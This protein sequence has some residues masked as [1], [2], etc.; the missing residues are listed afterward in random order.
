[1]TDVTIELLQLPD[2]LDDGTEA[3]R[4]FLEYVEVGNA[5]SREQAGGSD[6]FDQTP[7]EALGRAKGRTSA[8]QH[9]HIALL[10]G[11]V[12]GVGYVDVSLH[13][14]AAPAHA[15]IDVHPDFRRRGIGTKL[16]SSVNATLQ[17]EGRRA[18]QNWILHPSAPGPVRTAAT[19]FGH[20]P[21]ESDAVRF[22]EKAGFVLE[23]VERM[24]TLD[25]ADVTPEVLIR[26]QEAAQQRAHGY[27]VRAWTG[28]SPPDQLDQL[29]DLHA[30]MST[31]VPA[32][33]LDFEPEVWDAERLVK[34]ERNQI[35]DQGR[36]LLQAVAYDASGS[37]VAFTI[38]TLPPGKRVA[39]QDDTLVHGDHR[40]H[41][42][43]MLVKAA[44]LLQLIANHPDRQRV[45]TW[46]AVENRH[47]LDVNE[48]LGFKPAGD[49]GAWQRREPW[50][51]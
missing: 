9:R 30:R 46:N 19:G 29:A 49:E 1:M 13:E 39:F 37:P 5:V 42:L 40:G 34:A 23:Q 4:L 3:A 47:M 36:E 18:T 27:T 50:A 11:R 6:D 25:L 15:Y 28:Y 16:L 43:G 32:G 12:V 21:A 20:V 2:R 51:T 45:T 35:E 24:S 14:P 17:H 26:M 7:R 38:M 48:Q 8:R 22:L 41:R 33:D 10:D 31:D 44:N